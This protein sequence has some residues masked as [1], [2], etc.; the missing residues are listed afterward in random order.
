M[1]G[2]VLALTI[3][4]APVAGC[5][6]PFGRSEP[7]PGDRPDAA[8]APPDTRPAGCTTPY[9]GACTPAECGLTC[10]GELYRC[11]DG[12]WAVES[13]CEPCLGSPLL[14]AQVEWT[15]TLTSGCGQPAIPPPVR[16]ETRPDGLG[17]TSFLVV[18]PTPMGFS[19]DETF[20]NSL[21]GRG[22]CAAGYVLGFSTPWTIGG[23]PRQVDGMAE[24]TLTSGTFA[25][26]WPSEVTG[27]FQGAT[28]TG[29]QL[30]G[31]LAGT[32]TWL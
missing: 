17:G 16:F 21:A 13:Y 25:A 10:G 28:A 20:G 31:S 15:F 6:L 27:V 23:V 5:T 14:S 1:P 19:L 9:P 2:R 11:I 29:C 18:G 7:T 12:G 26:D 32:W 24:V 3:T 8:I 30:S 22:Q 4:L